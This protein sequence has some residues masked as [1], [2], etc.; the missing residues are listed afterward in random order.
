MR[1]QNY[2]LIGIFPR[3]SQVQIR[4]QKGQIQL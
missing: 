3:N 2:A 1:Y 4:C